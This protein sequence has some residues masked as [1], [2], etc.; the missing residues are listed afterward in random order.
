MTRNRHDLHIHTQYS[1][2]SN[3]VKEIVGR[4]SEL[5]LDYIGLMDHFWPSIG[6]H[7]RGGGPI[8]ER[9]RDIKNIRG[10][11]SGLHIFDG[12][13][14]DIRSDGTL[15]EVSGGLDQFELIIG[16][17]HSMMDS[18]RWA[19]TICKVATRSGFHILGHWHGYLTSYREADGE[20]VAKA[21]GENGIIV[22]ISS[23]YGLGNQDFYEM[24][25]DE[26]C[27]FSLGSDA[28]W[29]SRVGDTKE[30]LKLAEALELPLIDVSE[31]V[32]C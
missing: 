25:R 14:V 28:H 27:L 10:R 17:S 18:A 29:L 7:R 2:G 9:R 32:A 8:K 16:S 4:A 26:G 13:E 5:R 6:S 11:Y 3:S 1:D 30:Q 23:R 21:L 20:R 19:G 24:A 22:E 15:E 31:L 12:I